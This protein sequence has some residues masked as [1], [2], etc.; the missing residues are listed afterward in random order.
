MSYQDVSGNDITEGRT[1]RLKVM[2]NRTK[3]EKQ[4][5]KR[6]HREASR[7]QAT[8]LPDPRS[9]F[10]QPEAQGGVPVDEKTFAVVVEPIGLAGGKDLYFQSP[11]VVPFYLLTAKQLRDRAEPKRH[12][13]LTKTVTTPDETLRPLNPADSFDALEGL[14]LGVILSA[15]AIEAYANDVI[16]RLPDE[17]MVEVPTRL[18][19]QT[20][21][22]MRGK[23]AMD[24]LSIGE[25]LTRVVPLLTGRE[26]IKGTSAWQ[27]F[28]RVNK[29]RN[30]LVHIESVAR[31]DPNDPGPF[32]RLM[33]GEGSKAPEDAAS[34]IEALEPGWMPEHVRP[35]L[36]L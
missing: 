17:T 12:A 23:A 14:A 3:R 20:V 11:H 21:P 10:A 15:C 35:L 2:A 26:S 18:G 27:S 16:R 25:K 19:G 22:V 6:E 4:R 36:G 8:E 24:W 34:V 32:G 28:R 5:K 13:A 33:L 1:V 30:A 7:A 31:N 29:L 9:T